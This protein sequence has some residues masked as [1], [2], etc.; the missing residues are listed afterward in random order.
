MINWFARNG[1]AANLLMAFILLAGITTVSRIP[2]EVFPEIESDLITVQVPFRGSTP[3]EVEESVVVRIEEAIQDL[4]GIDEIRSTA[5]EGSGSVSIEV[6][7][8]YD[9]RELLDDVKNRIDAINTFPAETEK[10][11]IAIAQRSFSVM[12]VVLAGD[13]TERD[14]RKL[15]EQIR[16]EIANLPE[17]TQVSL[18][19]VRPY[20]IGIEISERTLQQYNLTIDSVARAIAQSSI[21]LPAGAIKTRGGEIMLRTKGQAYVKDDFEGIVLLTRE[22]GTRITVGEVAD[23]IDGFDETPLELT[24]NGDRSVLIAVNRVGDQNAITIASAVKDYLHDRQASLPPG[25]KLSYWSDSSRIVKGRLNTLTDSA[26]LGGLFVFLVLTLFLRFGLALWVCVGIPVSFMGSIFLMPFLGVTINIFSLFA[27]ILVLGIVVDDAIVTGEN[28]YTHL[29]RGSDPLKA[30]IEGTKEVAVPVTF[31]VLTTVIAFMPIA[32]IEGRRGPIFAQIPLIVIPVLLFS[33]VESKLILPSHLKHL[34]PTPSDPKKQSFLTRFQ[35]R[36][37]DGLEAFVLK[38]YRPL[39]AFASRRRYLTLSTFVG[40]T[41]IIFSIVASKRILFIFFPRV[42][43]EFATARLNMQLG[44]PIDVTAAQIDRIEEAARQLQEKYFDESLN[45]S[46][47]QNIMAVKGGSSLAGRGRRTVG[48]SHVGEVSMRLVPPEERT[49]PITSSEIV[50]EW[51][52]LIGVVPGAQNLSFRAEIGRSSDPIDIQ[53]TGPSFDELSD[54][55]S[56]IRG[57]LAEYPDLFDITDSFEAGKQ[58]IQLAI[59]PEAEALGLTMTDLARQVR[60]AF[61]GQEAQRI[62]RGREDVRVMVR[63]PLKE[64][65]SIENLMQMR[66]RTADG[67]EVPFSDVA[68][69]KMGRAFSTIRRIDRNRAINVTSD[70]NKESANLEAIKAD[71]SE[72]IPPIVAN[73]PGMQYTMEGEAREQSESF[74]SLRTGVLFVLFAIYA[75]LAIPFKSYVQPLMVMVVIPFGIAGA[76]VGHIIMGMNLSI[77]SIWGMLALSGIVVN[78]SLVLVDYINR[79]RSEGMPLVEAVRTAGVARFRAI[80]LTS[81]TTFAGLMPLIFEKST[82]AQVLIPMAVSLGF[83]ILFATAITLILVP[84]NYLILEDIQTYVAKYWKWQWD[85]TGEPHSD[86]DP[87]SQTA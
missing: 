38:Y 10:P 74:A 15:G 78:D 52:Q 13:L 81:L 47:I 55:S 48:Q 41:M 61:F 59:K 17:V 42:Q 8:G 30:A 25:V 54:A 11:V 27:F 84:I 71:L 21:D 86:K 68:E 67:R 32:L 3:A 35:R 87:E 73:Y 44:T 26:V 58:E 7:S 49:D 6:V 40:V 9:A 70:A 56:K 20:E 14:L 5:S 83:G 57:K 50:R 18:G 19:G 79:R 46:L 75:M 2:T 12:Q 64:R 37:A 66:V 23:V 63:Y 39:L 43:S 82:Q 29:Q 24:F 22:D 16:D 34:K 85:L 36:F 51:R 60:Q 33:L 45:G 53:L 4:E 28:I 76:I 1:V 72:I 62:Q 77:I 65:Q 80:I 69:A 31:G